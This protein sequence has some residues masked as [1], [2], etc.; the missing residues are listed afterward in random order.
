MIQASVIGVMGRPQ[1]FVDALRRRSA[2]YPSITME[3]Y[4]EPVTARTHARRE[5][6]WLSALV[7][8]FRGDHYYKVHLVESSFSFSAHQIAQITDLYRRFIDKAY[9]IQ[10]LYQLCGLEELDSDQTPEKTR[11]TNLLPK[12]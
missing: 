9:K 8:I 3:V 2:T 5:E 10:V 6:V 1:E 4:S 7:R 11:L 12:F